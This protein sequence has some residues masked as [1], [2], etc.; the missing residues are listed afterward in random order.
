MQ[1]MVNNQLGAAL[2]RGR[3]RYRL[4]YVLPWGR[5]WSIA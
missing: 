2:A 1:E 4:R 3:L 5:V